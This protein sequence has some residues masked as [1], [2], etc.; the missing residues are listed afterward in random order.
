[1]DFLGYDPSPPPVTLAQR[2]EAKRRTTGM[3]FDQVA[4]TLGWDHGTLTRYLNGT[5]RMPSSRAQALE[6]FL[7]SEGI[8]AA[9]GQGADQT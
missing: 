8:S 9:E 4:R 7:A 3:T 2:M 1:V 5:W 6:A